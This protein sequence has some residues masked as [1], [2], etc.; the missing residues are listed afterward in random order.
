MLTAVLMSTYNGELYIREQI[1][2]ILRQE[3][4]DV[5]LYI[6]DDGS[7]DATVRILEE[8]AGRYP[9]VIFVNRDQVSHL[10]VMKS[11][12][13]LLDYVYKTSPSDH[14]AFADQ[15]DV[16]LPAK[17]AS[18][19]KLLSAAADNEKGKLYYS[20]KTFVDADL[21]LITNEDIT[22]YDDIYEIFV[23]NRAS[24]CTMIFDGNLADY[25]LRERPEYEGVIHDNWTYRVAKAIGATVIFD[26]NSYILYRQHGNNVVGMQSV[27]RP[28][29]NLWYMFGRAVPVLFLHRRHDRFYAN[30]EIY[31]KY[32]QFLPEK[33]RKVMDR[34]V[35]YRYSPSAKM[36]LTFD[37]EMLRKRDLKRRLKWAYMIMFNR[38]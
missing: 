25:V 5:R 37:R 18:G 32:G 10:G 31:Y 35:R 13:S 8:Y 4:T 2:S 27:L 1:D 14:Y 21:N 30:R 15:D 24:G 7:S 34:F 28:Q 22:F 29:R 33:N 12:L 3:D 38:I 9:N 23:R 11:Y 26:N 17:L 6:R 19:I 20:N 16:W 36:L